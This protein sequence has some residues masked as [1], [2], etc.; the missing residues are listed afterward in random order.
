MRLTFIWGEFAYS[1]LRSNEEDFRVNVS[2]WWKCK[3][4]EHKEIPEEIQDISKIILDKLGWPQTWVIS[5][6]FGYDAIS[7][8]RKLIE[9]NDSPGFT[10]DEFV[11]DTTVIDIAFQKYADEFLRIWSEQ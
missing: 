3:N 9:F 5:M 6:D 11:S 1:E 7:N 10:N 4:I 2:L 8:S